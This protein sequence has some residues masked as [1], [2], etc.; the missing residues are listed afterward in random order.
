MVESLNLIEFLVPVRSYHDNRSLRN[1]AIFVFPFF[2]VADLEMVSLIL[3]HFVSDVDYNK[4]TDSESSRN[5]TDSGSVLVPMSWRVKL[6]SILIG[7]NFIVCG[8]EVVIAN[9]TDLVELALTK[10]QGFISPGV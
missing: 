3:E 8:N 1:H 2:N 4:R 6:C 9:S 5:V 7:W 10:H